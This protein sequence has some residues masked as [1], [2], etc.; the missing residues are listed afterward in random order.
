[1][2]LFPS[3]SNTVVDLSSP[4]V[5][6]ALSVAALAEQLRSAHQA[7]SDSRQAGESTVAR[8]VRE[9]TE[10]QTATAQMR[11]ALSQ[12]RCVVVMSR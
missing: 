10:A 8:A 1:L 2:F 9:R 12:L 6:T 11:D 4:S 5:L 3:F 7:L